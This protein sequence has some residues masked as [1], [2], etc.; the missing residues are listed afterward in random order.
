MQITQYP[1]DDTGCKGCFPVMRFLY[2]RICTEC[3][4]HVIKPVH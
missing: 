4:E 1:K 3:S 2:E